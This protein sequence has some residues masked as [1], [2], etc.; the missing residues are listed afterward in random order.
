MNTILEDF[1]ALKDILKSFK[2]IEK[3]YNWILTDL[4]WFYPDNYLDFF[5]DYRIND[6]RRIYLITGENLIKLANLKE[7]YFIWGVFSAFEKTEIIDLDN[8]KEEPYADGNPNFWVDNP[9]IQHSKAVAELVLWDSTLILLLSKNT[10][11]SRNFR[12]TFKGWKDLNT[13]NHS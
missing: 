4:D 1:I 7:V 13:Y 9:E 8:I 6:D 11:L 3:K 2:G 10:D 12:S 5:L